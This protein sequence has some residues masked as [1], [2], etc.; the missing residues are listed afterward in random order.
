MRLGGVIFRA[1]T[2][3]DLHR[4]VPVLDQ[5][6]LSAI[7]APERIDTMTADEAFEFGQ[8]AANLG[9]VVGESM[10]SCNLMS[11]D[12][13]RR[14]EHIAR[15]RSRLE[16]ADAMGCRGVFVGAGS[17]DP[18][19][20][21]RVPHPFMFTQQ[22]QAELRDVVLRVLDELDLDVVRLL[23]EPTNRTFF[24]QPEDIATFMDAVGHPSLGLHLD[25]ANMISQ[26]NYFDTT[27]LITRTFHL[28]ADRVVSAHL[29]DVHWDPDFYALKFDEVLIGDGVLDYPAYLS[30]L[31]ELDPDLTCFCEHLK[32]EEQYVANFVR[33]H[34]TAGALGLAFRGR[35]GHTV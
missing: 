33:L 5:Y 25:Q 27:D 20:L 8:L 29:K 28:L 12:T 34:D 32:T 7:P 31:D 2:I 17:V 30:R 19:G 6:G 14:A 26:S 23:I 16:L 10:L 35:D 9:L 11:S 24:Y 3:G 13:G 18:S 22:C 4:L 21:S 1:E 15:A